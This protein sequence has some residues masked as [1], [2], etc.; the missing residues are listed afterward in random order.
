MFRGEDVK[1]LVSVIGTDA[2][3][4]FVESIKGEGVVL[5]QR[6]MG[7]EFDALSPLVVEIDKENKKKDL[8]VLEI[9]I[10][11]LTPRIY[12]EYKNLSSLNVHKFGNQK[13]PYKNF[14]AEEQ[15]EIV[16]K[17][18]TTG[19]VTHKT[20]LSGDLFGDSSAVIGYFSQ[21]IM[22]NLRL[23]SGY[24]VLYE[25]VKEFVQ[26][27]LFAQSVDLNDPNTL[28]NLSE[29]EATRTIVETFTKEINNLTVQDRGEAE[30]SK[31]LKVGDARPFVVKGQES[32][33]P[34]KSIFNRIVGDSYFEL[35]FAALLEKCDDVMAYVKNYFAVGLRI[36][37]QNADGE[38]S[39]FHP[40]FVVKTSPK[41][42]WIVETKGREDLDDPLKIKRLAQWCEDVNTNQ[43]KIKISW[44]YVTQDEYESRPFHSF[45]DLVS[46]FTSFTD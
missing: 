29:I 24:D 6:R 25:K 46:Q 19:D 41:E 38:I 37:Y 34:Q 39:N 17:D 21:T 4:A 8:D 16:F 43:S 11:Q 22:R 3:M 32:L 2:F 23:V 12:R 5:E 45:S 44:L 13:V 27:A 14:T 15:R 35:Q 33:I 10:P 1:E 31:T 7:K 30:I 36:D 18:I 9:E 28:R 20:M 26:D 42:L 40:D